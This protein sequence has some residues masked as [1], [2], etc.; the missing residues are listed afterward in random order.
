MK[1]KLLIGAL[2]AV[3]AFACTGAVT[4]L[5][6]NGAT[7]T[8]ATPT[9]YDLWDL[10]G[11]KEYQTTKV[12]GVDQ[13]IG[14]FERNHNVAFRSVISYDGTDAFKVNHLIL[15]PSQTNASHFAYG[16]YGY[17]FIVDNNK[18]HIRY[19]SDPTTA[20]TALKTEIT[21]AA[22][23]TGDSLTAKLAQT[24]NLSGT[25]KVNVTN[26]LN[27]S[28][29][30][31]LEFG[32]KDILTDGTWTGN[33]VYAAINGTEVLS[34]TDTSEYFDDMGTYTGRGADYREVSL[35][36]YKTSYTVL[37]FTMGTA[38]EGAGFETGDVYQTVVNKNSVLE[39]AISQEYTI[40]SATL[41][42]VDVT[43]KI[44]WTPTGYV[45]DCTSFTEGGTLV[46]TTE[47]SVR[48]N[49]SV[50]DLYDI[51]GKKSG[52]YTNAYDGRLVGNLPQ[53]HNAAFRAKVTFEGMNGNPDNRNLLLDLILFSKTRYNVADDYG[54][55]FYWRDGVLKI[56]YDTA[57][58]ENGG[59]DTVAASLSHA[60]LQALLGTATANNLRYCK[61]SFVLEFGSVKLINGNEWTGNCVYVNINGVEVLSFVDRSA[62]YKEK[63]NI[64]ANGGWANGYS[65]YAYETAYPYVEFT[66]GETPEGAKFETGDT[67]KVLAVDGATL[68]LP[69][70]F[71]YILTSATLDNVDITDKISAN[72]DGYALDCS[73]FTQGG[74]LVLTTALKKV[75]VAVTLN[76]KVTVTTAQTYDIKSFLDVKMTTAVGYALSSFKVNGEEKIAD[77]V[78]GKDGTYTYDSY[79]LL[80]QT[81]TIST[82]VEQKTFA[83]TVQKTGDGTVQFA[84]TVDAFGAFTLTATPDGD[85]SILSVKCNGEKLPL[86]AE[87]K[88][89][90]EKVSQD[91]T[92]EVVFS[93]AEKVVNKENQ[94]PTTPQGESGCG[95][96]L[97]VFLPLTACL[98][99]IGT[100]L[101]MRARTRKD[102]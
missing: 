17:Q 39:L 23:A 36:K 57:P 52:V 40:T 31:L 68:H 74:T 79:Q 14:Q 33:Y 62:N 26:L 58:N 98:G 8:Q 83:V 73:G 81:V 16:G 32:C 43:D 45:L 6:A 13:H 5:T 101:L 78:L 90:L 9:V 29:A 15:T 86:N 46:L 56:C 38:P 84:Q 80:A 67:H 22:T 66:M 48:E 12:N 18:M 93:V 44:S 55:Q 94:T 64:I 60:G 61:E 63:G 10:K 100:L 82:A 3:C 59:N 41:A 70:K 89:T 49:A 50:Y 99:L 24:D 97:G 7:S 28:E 91:L 75:N 54:Y 72:D 4:T 69:L 11:V 77:V 1:K 37:D 95:S 102:D 76:D 42:S 85:E 30:F 25:G 51:T 71:G 65:L 21:A 19:D 96:S 34:Y 20:T 92:F 53:T 87:G 47:K 2:S 35:F 27:G 88:F